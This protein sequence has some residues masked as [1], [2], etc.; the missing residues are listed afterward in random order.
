VRCSETNAS[1]PTR[2]ITP[3]ARLD[4]DARALLVRAADRLAL[5]ARAY[6]R[7][8]RVARTIA[9]LDE[10]DGVT[11]EHIGEALR[12]RPVTV[13]AQ[14]VEARHSVEPNPS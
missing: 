12:Y 3:A 8:L 14:L 2:L 9:D 7:V 6:H 13:E 5:S 11:R 4:A 1:A 10:V